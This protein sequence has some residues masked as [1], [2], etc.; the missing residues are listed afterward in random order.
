LE[1]V[2]RDE[3]VGLERQAG[4]GARVDLPARLRHR[5]IRMVQERRRVHRPDDVDVHRHFGAEPGHA[6]FRREAHAAEDLHGAG[7]APLHLRQELRCG[8]ALDER[9][10]H[11]FLAE[12]DREDQANR[13]RADD[14]NLGVEQARRL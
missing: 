5:R 14:E 9:A 1:R 13:P 6:H 10:A 8:L 12:V 4:V 7:V 2:L 11:A 3:L